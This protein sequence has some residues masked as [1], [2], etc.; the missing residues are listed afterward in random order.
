LIDYLS[1]RTIALIE[2]KGDDLGYRFPSSTAPAHRESAARPAAS[3]DVG[4]TN[5]AFR[6]CVPAAG[7][8]TLRTGRAS[9]AR[10]LSRGLL[11]IAAI[12]EPHRCLGRDQV[13]GTDGLVGI[14]PVLGSPPTHHAVVEVGGSAIRMPTQVFTEKIV[15]LAPLRGVFHSYTHVMLSQIAQTSACNTVHT[16]VQRRWRRR[17]A[18]TFHRIVDAPGPGL[19]SGSLWPRRNVMPR[20][21]RGYRPANMEDSF[22]RGM[23]RNKIALALSEQIETP[24]RAWRRA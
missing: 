13:V 11:R 15:A 23:P 16:L 10:V 12:P 24:V 8:H 20:I 21:D 19:L 4:E 9:R 7:R 22:R 17:Q 3:P 6:A 5:G 2:I 14:S 1:L 18:M